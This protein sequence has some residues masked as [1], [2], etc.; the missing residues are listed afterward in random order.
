VYIVKSGDYADNIAA[1][2]NL[3]LWELKLANPQV[4]DLNHIVVGQ[5]LNIPDAGQMSRPSAA[6]S[7]P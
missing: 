2:F 6:P 7:V 1:R 5:S 4:P 3:Q